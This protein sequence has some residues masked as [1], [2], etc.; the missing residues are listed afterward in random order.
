[1]DKIFTWDIDLLNPQPGQWHVVSFNLDEPV[2]LENVYQCYVFFMTTLINYIAKH[3]FKGGF[4]YQLIIEG[5]NT[6]TNEQQNF[7]FRGDFYSLKDP[8]I[9][10]NIQ[11]FYKNHINGWLTNINLVFKFKINHTL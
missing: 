2:T 6:I 10:Q 5:S 9:L 7:V 3:L 4:D 1:M 11:D 8:N